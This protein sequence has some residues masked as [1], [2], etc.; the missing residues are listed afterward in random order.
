[1][2]EKGK[3]GMNMQRDRFGKDGSMEQNQRRNGIRPLLHYLRDAARFHE[4]GDA[5]AARLLFLLTAGATFA[6]YA[7]LVQPL[8]R[9]QMQLQARIDLEALGTPDGVT[10]AALLKSFGVVLAIVLAGRC[11]VLAVSAFYQHLYFRRASAGDRLPM[12][13]SIHHYLRYLPTILLSNVLFWILLA[14]GAVFGYVLVTLAA[15]AIP[16]LG[17]LT[18]A[19][20]LAVIVFLGLFSMISLTILDQNAGPVEAFGAALK[21]ASCDARSRGQL[22]RNMLGISLAGILANLAA[23]SFGRSLAAIF[24]AST[25][26][27]VSLLIIA[28]LVA[29]MYGDAVGRPI[30]VRPLLPG[31]KWPWEDGGKRGGR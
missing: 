7:L 11:A 17:I 6:M 25:V 8:E 5:P 26:E 16:V 14:V 31:V 18:L 1:M 21:T 23:A 28:K 24:L 3:E 2:R 29:L 10:D 22:I 30:P 4:I 27:T 15:A 12:R 9:F 20:P 13:A 19:P